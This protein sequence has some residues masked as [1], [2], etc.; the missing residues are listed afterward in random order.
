MRA[1]RVLVTAVLLAPFAWADEPTKESPAGGDDAARVAE[2]EAA[3]AQ[4]KKDK[5]EN[6]LVAD[7]DSIAAAHRAAT[8][9]K[10]QERLNALFGVILAGTKN[11]GLEKAVLKTIGDL[12]DAA[13]WKHVRPFLQQPDPKVQPPLLLDGIEAAGKLKADGAIEPLLKIAD[14]SKV[15]PAAAAAIRA[16][17][18]YGEN[19][20]NRARILEEI[21]DTVR[22]SIPGGRGMQKGGANP[23][24]DS[25]GATNASGNG[26]TSR[27]GTLAPA[28][29]EAA[30]K[31]T[32][33]SAATAED[34]FEIYAR[35]KS[36]LGNLFPK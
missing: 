36:K 3:V 35:N 32:G 12:G 26:D 33:Q 22:R 34:W 20:R 30:N 29:V 23:D 27:W 18:C 17:G 13:N 2:V 11:D 16:L 25:G 1:A 14:K 9:P 21:I 15:F 19:K 8:D 6:A 4:H 5:D 24:D 28:L 7:L 31:M 10:L